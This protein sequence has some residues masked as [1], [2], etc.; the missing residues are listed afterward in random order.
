MP[1]QHP[2]ESYKPR[3]SIL[4]LLNHDVALKQVKIQYTSLGDMFVF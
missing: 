4:P 2:T 1:T 3:L